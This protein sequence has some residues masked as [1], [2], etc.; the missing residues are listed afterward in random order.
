MTDRDCLLSIFNAI[1]G[2]AE[3][4]TGERMIVRVE[5]GGGGVFDLSGSDVT[6][7]KA[8]PEAVAAPTYP[9]AEPAPKS[10]ALA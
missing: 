5:L 1:C 8:C 4:L 3:R 9:H 10:P 2:L 7:E 6:W